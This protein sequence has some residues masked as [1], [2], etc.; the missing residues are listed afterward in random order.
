MYDE[1]TLYTLR[2]ISALTKQFDV[3]SMDIQ[4]KLLNVIGYVAGSDTDESN[5]EN[6][7]EVFLKP[8]P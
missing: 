1:N 5:D 4:A 7:K 3:L 8:L 6:S 2:R